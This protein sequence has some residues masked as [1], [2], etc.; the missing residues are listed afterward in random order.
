MA[1]S[2]RAIPAAGPVPGESAP[3]PV[4]HVREFDGRRVL[5]GLDLDIAPGSSADYHLLTV[6]TK[7]GISVHDVTLVY[8]QPA[9]GLAALTTA[10]QAAAQNFGLDE[11]PGHRERYQRA[12]EFVDVSVAL[13]GSWEDGAEI[14]DKASGRYADP[15]L[16]HT[17]KITARIGAEVTGLPADLDLDP[18]TVAAVRAALN[19]HKACAGDV[20]ARPA[21]AVRQPD[22]PALRDRQLRRRPAPPA[23]GHRGR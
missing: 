4:Q 11:V 13:W 18:D 6:L 20:G 15:A 2:G 3:V 17:R 9:A 16:I 12:A 10:T 7:A 22:H 19:E 21:G 5:D 14:G 1:A 8:L 23:P